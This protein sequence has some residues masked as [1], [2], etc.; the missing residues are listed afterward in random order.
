VA[1][2]SGGKHDPGALPGQG[3]AGATRLGHLGSDGQAAATLAEATAPA[4]KAHHG[5]STSTA[6]AAAA[7]AQ[8][9]SAASGLSHVITGSDAGGLGPLLPILLATALIAAVGLAVARIRRGNPP[10]IGA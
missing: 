10:E 3:R 6:S 9:S 1:P 8:G 4:S 7:A 5:S 2:P